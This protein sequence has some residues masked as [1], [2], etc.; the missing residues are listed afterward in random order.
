MAQIVNFA[1]LK[2]QD[3]KTKKKE[4]RWRVLEKGNKNAIATIEKDSKDYIPS[5]RLLYN[6][7]THRN[8]SVRN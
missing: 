3:R 1:D 6:Q 2:R 4:K 5:Y 7:S 8:D